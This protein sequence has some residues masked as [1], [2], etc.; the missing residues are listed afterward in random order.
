M[1]P[2]LGVVY[3]VNGETDLEERLL[4]H[5][6]GYRGSK[7]V[8]RGNC[9]H[10]QR[11]IDVYGEV[12]DWAL[13]YEALGGSFDGGSRAMLAALANFVA[14]HWREPDQGL[15]EM[16]GPVGLYSEA[17]DPKELTFLGNFPQAYTHLALVCSAVHLDL[18]DRQG[19][20][21]LEGS[22]ADRAKRIASATLGWRALW[23]AFKATRTVGRLFSS[24]QSVLR[25]EAAWESSGWQR[26]AV[27]LAFG[28]FAP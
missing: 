13:L 23:A 16:R 6:E 26:K 24:K 8:R 25:G 3:G 15:W 17:I 22:H 5:L 19:R 11:Q 18:Y 9:A 28:A 2:D 7:P 14:D 27:P 10:T 1:A 21:A 20:E 4:S 12:L